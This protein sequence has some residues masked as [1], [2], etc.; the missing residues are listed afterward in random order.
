MLDI[1]EV[2]HF[3]GTDETDEDEKRLVERLVNQS[4]SRLEVLTKKNWKED[5][6]ILVK[7]AEDTVLSMVYLDYYC[8]RDESKNTE[9]LNNYIDSNIFLLILES[10]D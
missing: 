9:F 5:T 10:D 6:S 1:S 3:L 4:Y 2:C 7:I 8:N